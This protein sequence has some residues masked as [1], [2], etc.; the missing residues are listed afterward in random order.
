MALF[1][2]I[3]LDG[4][5]LEQ[6]GELD[7]RDERE[8]RALLRAQRVRVVHLQAG[9]LPEDGHLG[10]RLVQALSP[11]LPRSWM[12]V[13]SAD[14][15]LMFRQLS[16]ML[17]AGHTLVAALDTSARLTAKLRARHM[18]RALA[19][20][21]RAGHTLSDAMREQGRPFSTLMVAL[22]ESGETSGELDTVLERLADDL[23]RRT[24]LKRQL[25]TALTYPGIVFLAAIGVVAFLVM[26]VIPRFATFLAGSGKEL[27]AAATLLLD[28]SAWLGE[29]GATLAG[30]A[31]VLAVGLAVASTIAPA[32]RVI[33][34]ALLMV[35]VVGGTLS[36][37]AMAQAAWTLA[38]LVKSGTTVLQS[39]NVTA[40]VVGNQAI[41]EGFH[42]A[43]KD[44]LTGRSVSAAL[45]QV[46]IPPLMRHM[47]EVGESSGELDT[48][49]E[50][51]GRYYRKDLDAKVKVL[52]ALIEPVL[53][54][55]VGGIVGFVYF[56]FF[57]AV[58]TVSAR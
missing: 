5:G 44:V 13:R 20:R 12:P 46:V 8:A 50:A 52:S 17:R 19:E 38:M 24:E 56:A 15:A 21:L 31:L 27:P 30:G 23:D 2:Y 45:K 37:A 22:I 49:M 43:A 48:V 16:L 25:V 51:V 35:P 3:A 53:I 40:R 6:R 34:R 28:I 36:A 57:Q 58:M 9:P 47:A 55:F 26:M 54:L 10:F 39:L 42:T 29:W 1:G 14:L 33:D 32:R 4:Q 41:A 18:V 11:A 7:A